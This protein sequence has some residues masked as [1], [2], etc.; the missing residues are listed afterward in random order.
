MSNGA[1]L[2]D[3][4]VAPSASSPQAVSPVPASIPSAWPETLTADLR[5]I[6]GKMCFEFIALSQLY[7][8]AGHAI[9]Q[10]AEDEQAYFLHKFLGF[11]FT[12][13]ADWREPAIAELQ[14]VKAAA[15]AIEARSGET[16]QGLDPKDESA[17]PDRADAQATTEK[18]N[19]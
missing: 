6:L 14:A 7:R 13:G 12:H 11:W 3:R 10:A 16:R 8:A 18:S 4:A 9:P 17:V 15:S 19:G 2:R 1:S 5:S